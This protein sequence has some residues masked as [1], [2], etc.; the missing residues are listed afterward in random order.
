MDNVRFKHSTTQKSNSGGAPLRTT[1]N[2]GFIFAAN[3]FNTD[4]N[5]FNSIGQTSSSSSDIS[6]GNSE[7]H[8]R[9]KYPTNDLYKHENDLIKRKPLCAYASPTN[10][11]KIQSHLRNGIDRTAKVN[12][13]PNDVPI[14]SDRNKYPVPNKQKWLQK[15]YNNG[16]TVM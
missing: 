11:V 4:S 6:G 16:N 15:N 1:I 5:R 8:F 9:N 7:F 2:N 14:T 13:V 3:T 12:I 10:Q